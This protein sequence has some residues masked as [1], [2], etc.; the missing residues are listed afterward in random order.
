MLG[1]LM[2]VQEILNV[3][4]DLLD[5]GVTLFNITVCG[6]CSLSEFLIRGSY[7]KS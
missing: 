6:L 3:A 4:F 7:R 1:H 2:Y 5:N